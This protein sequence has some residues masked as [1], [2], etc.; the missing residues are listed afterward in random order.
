MS[1]FSG[2]HHCGFRFSGPFPHSSS[3]PDTRPP[4]GVFCVKHKK[5]V[6]K[7]ANIGNISYLCTQMVVTFEETKA[8]W[9]QERHFIGEGE[10]PIPDRVHRGNGGWQ[11]N[12]NHL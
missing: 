11:A 9:R 8:G 1:N 6:L 2:S 12:C 10:R 5:H 3:P 4:E 7:F